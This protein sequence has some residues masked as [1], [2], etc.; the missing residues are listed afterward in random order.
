MI[1]RIVQI[2]VSAGGVP[3]RPVR[4]ARVTL[5]RLEGDGHRNRKLHGGPDRA[6]CLF[7]LEQIEA[8]QAEG[9]PVEPGALGENLTVAGLDVQSLPPGCL[10][11]IG[12]VLLEL[13]APR[14]PCYVLDEIDPRLKDVIVGRCGYMAAVL[15]PGTLSPGLLIQ[16]HANSKLNRTTD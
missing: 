9:H 14:K 5:G 10:L 13:M 3:K 8:L 2:N 1:G 7:S 4:T 16:A 15:H 11:E 6:L 12:D